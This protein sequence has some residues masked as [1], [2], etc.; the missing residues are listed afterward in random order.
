VLRRPFVERHVTEEPHDCGTA[1]CR[2]HVCKP[3]AAS[4]I[5]SL[6]AILSGACG[7]AVRWGWLTFQLDRPRRRPAL[8][9]RARSVEQ[10]GRCQ[11]GAA[12]TGADWFV[13]GALDGDG[14]ALV[15][16]A[17][18]A[19]VGS[20]LHPLTAD[21]STEHAAIDGLAAGQTSIGGGL[22]RALD[23]LNSPPEPS[24]TQA[25]VLLTD[26]QH[27]A[28]EPPGV[29][30]PDLRASLTRVYT[31]GIGPTLDDT[32]LQGLADATG[33]EFALRPGPPRR[34]AGLR[35]PRP[36]RASH[37]ARPRR[38]GCGRWLARTSGVG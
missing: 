9:P 25:V 2:H 37:R 26:G 7:A 8:R 22:R 14:V 6:H 28:G 16:Y 1:G 31:V 15:S 30:L 35:D 21:R 13:D 27:N 20:A 3:Y 36:Y 38:R 11:A 24:S 17:S 29:V 5:R 34:R 12:K 19:T 18:T 23:E 32:L 10:H 33:G 4:S